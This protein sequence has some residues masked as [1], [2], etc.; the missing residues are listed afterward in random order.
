MHPYIKNIIVT[1]PDKIKRSENSNILKLSKLFFNAIKWHRLKKLKIYQ[2]Y[3]N[4]LFFVYIFTYAEIFVYII[5]SEICERCLILL[6]NLRQY[7]IFYFL[8]DYFLL[9]SKSPFVIF[10]S[11]KTI[12]YAYWILQKDF[13]VLWRINYR[14]LVQMSM[15]N[16]N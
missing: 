3:Q 2:R 8:N 14:L 10:I 15:T 13:Y 7:Y 12:Y 6:R 11:Y 9:F 5:A 1:F 4:L 16:G